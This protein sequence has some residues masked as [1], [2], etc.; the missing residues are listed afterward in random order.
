MDDID[1]QA[2]EKSIAQ[3]TA[4]LQKAVNRNNERAMETY[5][6]ALQALL[7]LRAQLRE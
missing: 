3:A 5:G 6:L 1:T 4:Q 7:A 2:V